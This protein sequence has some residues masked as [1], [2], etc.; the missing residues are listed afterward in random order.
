MDVTGQF[1]A[2][3]ILSL[4]NTASTYLD[5]RMGGSKGWSEYVAKEKFASR[6]LG[7]EP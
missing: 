4:R 6:L 5:R 7:F 3:A 1:H 2:P